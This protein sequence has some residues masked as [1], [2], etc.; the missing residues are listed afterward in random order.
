MKT[1]DG[2]Q[3]RAE[4]NKQRIIF[5]LSPRYFDINEADEQLKKVDEL[6]LQIAFANN[7]FPVPGGPKSKTPF[8]GSLIPVKNSGITRGKTIASLRSRLAV[9]SAAMSL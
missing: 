5:S 2:A 7:V 9:S 1:I 3:I 6:K 8:H 4:S